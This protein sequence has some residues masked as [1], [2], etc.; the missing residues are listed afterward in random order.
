MKWK[1]EISIQRGKTA[2][3]KQPR[4]TAAKA[5]QTPPAPKKELLPPRKA[6]RDPG[7]GVITITPVRKHSQPALTY[8]GP[9]KVSHSWDTS[10][11]QFEIN[12]LWSLGAPDDAPVLLQI[13]SHSGANTEFNVDEEWLVLPP[14]KFKNPNRSWKKAVK[15]FTMKRPTKGK[16]SVKSA[17]PSRKAAPAAKKASAKPKKAAPAK[18]KASARRKE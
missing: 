7:T 15:N 18:K 13:T 6:I 17:A 1:V 14:K 5:G 16:R 9:Y 12:I 10:N 11:G 3:A 4:K 2:M 8:S